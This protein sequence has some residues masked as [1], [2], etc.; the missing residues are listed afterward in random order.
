MLTYCYDW[1]N[2]NGLIETIYK[3]NNFNQIIKKINEKRYN[4]IFLNSKEG[5]SFD[6]NDNQ[7]NDYSQYIVRN[8]FKEKIDELNL[9]KFKTFNITIFN[10]TYSFLL[11][12]RLDR[13]SM[14]NFYNKQNSNMT[15]IVP[16]T[17]LYAENS[18][19]MLAITYNKD[20]KSFSLSISEEVKDDTVCYTKGEPGTILACLDHAKYGIDFGKM[21]FCNSADYTVLTKQNIDDA[22]EMY[23]VDIADTWK[24]SCQAN[25]KVYSRFDIQNLPE[26][27][28]VRAINDAIYDA[29]HPSLVIEID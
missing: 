29:L 1:D 9:L 24:P 14:V 28:M 26:D 16:V 2:E 20:T 4:D 17:D 8:D 19:L 18:N 23:G 11:G 27:S 7:G 25:S 15:T 6:E 13:E 22:M 12:L 3:S 10:E 5:G 21:I